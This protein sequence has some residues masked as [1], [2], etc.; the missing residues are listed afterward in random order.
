MLMLG[1]F[2][3]I[4]AATAAYFLLKLSRTYYRPLYLEVRND[5]WLWRTEHHDWGGWHKPSTTANHT[6]NCFSVS[7]SSNSHGARDRERSITAAA[8]RAILLGDS[9]IEG[10][11]VD[12][13]ER[14]SNLLEER[15][16]LEML[17]FGMTHFGPL[18]YQILYEKLARRFDHELVMIG[19]LPNNDFTGNDP[20][21]GRQESDFARR[22]RPYYS[23]DGGIFYPRPRPSPD[24]AAVFAEHA[25]DLPERRRLSQNVLRLFWLYGLYREI[26]FNVTVLQYPVPSDYIGYFETDTFRIARATESILAIQKAAA[27]RPVLVFFIPDYDSWSYVERHPGSYAQSVV[28]SL[29]EVFEHNG[30]T[31]IDLL[32][33]FMNRGLD[34]DSLYL[35]CDGHWNGRGHRAALDVIAPVV[36]ELF[37]SLVT[38]SDSSPRRSNTRKDNRPPRP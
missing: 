17:N 4:E 3:L 30:I 38:P 5:Q 31:T 28:A 29:R 27:P 24:E 23:K 32:T 11:G 14:L 20:D 22:Y 36:R 12:E 13:E 7:Y 9:F 35:P 18:Q 2:A 21:F 26:R 15:L 1:T 10:Y 37:R 25:I 19:F 8:N 33:E 6:H 34:K 16:G